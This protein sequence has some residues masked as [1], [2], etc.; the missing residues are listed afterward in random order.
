LRGGSTAEATDD[1]GDNAAVKATAT[2]EE[3]AEQENDED[4]AA[5]ASVMSLQ[6]VRLLIQTNWGNSVVGHRVE[7]MAAQTRTVASLKKSVSRHFPRRP[8][9]LDL[10]LVLATS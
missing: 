6:P 5:L 7:L 4:D 10:E 3:G 1:D 2:I 8:S 9:I